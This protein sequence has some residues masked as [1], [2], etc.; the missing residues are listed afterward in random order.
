VLEDLALSA[1]HTEN[2]IQGRHANDL[3]LIH[4]E[5]KFG[6]ID[7]EYDLN[8]CVSASE[9]GIEPYPGQDPAPTPGTL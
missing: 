4:P 5:Y 9:V 6:L 3:R 8:L 7:L 2:P 1:G